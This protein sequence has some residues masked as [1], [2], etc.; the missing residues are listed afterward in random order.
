MVQHLVER[1]VQSTE[2]FKGRLLHAFQDAV[3][4]PGG[5][6]A[7]RE[8][9]MH[10]GA[11]MVVGLLAQDS[12][13]AQLILERQF[14]YPVQQ[15]I[16]EFPAGKLDPG[17][18]SL[19]CAMRELREETGYTAKQWAYAGCLYPVVAYSTERIDVW[20]AR[21]LTL[22]SR[23]LDEGETLDVFTATL[24]Q[25]LD[26]CRDGTVTDAKTLTGVLWLQNVLS[27]AW[28]LAWRPA[29]SLNSGG[30]S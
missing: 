16:I 5:S 25:L 23:A 21:H 27:G 17:E 20:F 19:A 13:E 14:R 10:P 29:P 22:G 1:R 3:A 2:V 12:G 26:W 4:L 18:D 24:P 11:V 15:V 8:Y 9:V 28:Q 7:T 30:Q 6:T